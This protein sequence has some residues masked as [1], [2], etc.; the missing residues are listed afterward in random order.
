MLALVAKVARGCEPW[1][2]YQDI[3]RG[4]Y[5]GYH[6]AQVQ[7][8]HNMTVVLDWALSQSRD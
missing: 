1:Q 5:S 2:A 6:V 7:Y 4:I 8:N 3:A